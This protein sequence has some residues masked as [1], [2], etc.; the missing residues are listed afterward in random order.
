MISKLL[1]K[2]NKVKVMVLFRGREITHPQLGK[3]LLDN[4]AGDLAEQATV[5]RP[6]GME[7]RSMFMILAPLSP[8]K[9]KA[10]VDNVGETINA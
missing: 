8:K 3:E 7:G 1:E 2:G 9:P 5:E 4:V 6:A 10:K